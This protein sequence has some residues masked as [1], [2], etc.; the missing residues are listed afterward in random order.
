MS[1]DGPVVHANMVPDTSHYI[2]VKVNGI[3]YVKLEDARKLR[4]GWDKADERIA[5]LEGLIRAVHR[6]AKNLAGDRTF[7]QCITALMWIDD[8]CRDALGGKKDE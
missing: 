2:G 3:L 4:E 8:L 5:E 1:D 6:N 7:D